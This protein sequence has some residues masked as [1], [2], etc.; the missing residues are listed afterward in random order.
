MYAA[1]D[2][3]LQSL[4]K[5]QFPIIQAP[6]AGVMDS[7]MVIA[8]SQ[9][10]GL[11]SLPCAMLT[12]AQIRSE[13]ETIRAQTQNPINVNFFCHEPP[14]FDES[15]ELAWK[16]RL[17]TY[18]VELGLDPDA[19]FPH[20]SRMPFDSA[21]CELVEEFKPEVVSFH[22]GLP[23]QALLTRV[24]ATGAKVLS[25]ATTVEE[26]RY[27]EDHG[28]DAIIAQGYEAGGHRGMFLTEDITT[29]IGTMALVPQIV[30]A[31][32]VPVIA[33]GGIADGRGIMASFAL[34]ASAVQIG[35]AFLFCPEAKITPAYRN[36]LENKGQ[37]AITNVFSG[38]PARG[39][40][41]RL[42]R[43]L[44]PMCDLAPAFPLAG[45][46]IAPIRG[47]S[48]DF[49]QMWSGQA[50]SLGR[51][52]PAGELTILLASESNMLQFPSR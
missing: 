45:S 47:K 11:G 22:F 9:A 24:K 50:A 52:L 30:D 14:V 33:A 34:G 8:V 40:V 41:N 13:L 7:A 21:A 15:R 39:I 31:V 43:E 26:A 46:A 29:Q 5:I 49:A 35:T 18:Y 23:D 19:P 6:M 10:G 32:K 16:Q 17:S 37:T 27:L 4:L 3:R 28:C 25:S 42:V 12:A 2:L 38:R 48:E 1:P 20:A 44:G 36:A 51:E